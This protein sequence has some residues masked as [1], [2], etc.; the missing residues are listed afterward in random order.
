MRYDE[1][2]YKSTQESGNYGV[3]IIYPITDH[4]NYNPSDAA[5]RTE[6]KF[7][8]RNVKDQDKWQ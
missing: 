5:I 2:L 3:V 8:T 6:N 1:G 7:N 4:R